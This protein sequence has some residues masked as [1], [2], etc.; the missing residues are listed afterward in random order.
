[1][2]SDVTLCNG[3]HPVTLF[4][5]TWNDHFPSFDRLTEF[6]GHANLSLRLG[7]EKASD[8]TGALTS[9]QGGKPSSCCVGNPPLKTLPFV[10]Y[11]WIK[12]K[13]LVDRENITVTILSDMA[14]VQALMTPTARGTV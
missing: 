5:N 2:A 12:A 8:G 13:D 10:N 9:I 1:M 6:E 3:K 7:V 14:E 11:K 4:I